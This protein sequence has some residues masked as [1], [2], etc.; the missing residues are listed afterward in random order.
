MKQ[1]KQTR[2]P[3]WPYTPQRVAILKVLIAVGVIAWCLLYFGCKTTDWD[4]ASKTDLE[5]FGSKLKETRQTV[6]GLANHTAPNT[7]IALKAAN[8]AKEQFIQQSSILASVSNELLYGGIA[9]LTGGPAGL[10]LH[11]RSRAKKIIKK[12][13]DMEPDKAREYVLKKT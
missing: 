2:K 5:A 3:H 7:P 8:E 10:M 11:A 12:V 13:A 1:E 6:S 9:L 4:P